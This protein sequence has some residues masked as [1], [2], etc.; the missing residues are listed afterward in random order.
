MGC[1]V[2]HA[3]KGLIKAKYGEQQYRTAVAVLVHGQLVDT[4]RL[5]WGPGLLGHVHGEGR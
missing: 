2:Y 4:V 3:L 5:L 1:E